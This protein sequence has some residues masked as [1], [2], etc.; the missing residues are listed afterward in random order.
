ML[1]PG[2]GGNITG[3]NNV[4]YSNTGFYVGL[5][6]LAAGL[7]DGHDTKLT[8]DQYDVYVNH[9]YIGKKVLLAQNETPT[10]VE[11]FLVKQGFQ[12]FTTE[13]TGDHIVIHAG[14]QEDTHNMKEILHSYLEIR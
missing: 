12:G 13:V 6:L 5:P 9:D 1:Y 7:T 8:H 14:R 3:I 2:L 11:K 10:D 4:N